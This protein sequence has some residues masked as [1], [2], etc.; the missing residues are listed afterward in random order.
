MW[1]MT[2]PE[3][4]VGY[5]SPQD[6]IDLSQ[7]IRDADLAVMERFNAPPIDVIIK[8]I[9]NSEK[10][11]A[12][13]VNGEVMGIWGF[14]RHTMLPPIGSVWLI[15]GK[16]VEKHKRLFIEGT[17]VFL[18]E[19]LLSCPTLR[20]SVAADYPGAIKLMQYLGFDLTGPKPTG[21][22]GMLFYDATI[23]W[24]GV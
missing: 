17:R 21:P 5:V 15:T 20:C 10:C 24:G 13:R 11:W 23:E 4:T 14:V 2:K 7:S 22:D 19:I 8:S 1:A 9:N 6:A 18:N 12:L 16:V 3:I